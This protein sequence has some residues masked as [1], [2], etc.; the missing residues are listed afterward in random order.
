MGGHHLN[1]SRAVAFGGVQKQL[2]PAQCHSRHGAQILPSGAPLKMS[3]FVIR[4]FPLALLRNPYFMRVKIARSRITLPRAPLA[5]FTVR[6][7]LFFVDPN[8]QF[9]AAFH[10]QFPRTNYSYFLFALRFF[11]AACPK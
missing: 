11:R 1:V 8:W 2:P 10:A 6:F 4:S 5:L 3:S 7:Y 9:R